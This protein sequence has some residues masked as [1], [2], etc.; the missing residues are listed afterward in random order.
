MKRHRITSLR[1]LLPFDIPLRRAFTKV[2][3]PAVI[4]FLPHVCLSA[5]T[6]QS[7]DPW[8]QWRGP[9]G[10]GISD[11]PN[12]PVHWSQDS[13]NIKWKA[14]IPGEGVSSPIVSNGRV[15]LTTA[16]ES[17]GAAVL[18][19]MVQ[20]AGIAL[21]IVLAAV[22][23]I[24]GIRAALK[25]SKSSKPLPRWPAIFITAVPTILFVDLALLVTVARTTAQRFFEQVGGLFA[26]V[27]TGDME[28]LWSMQEGVLAA[29]WLTSGSITLLGLAVIPA[30]LPRRSRW[31][32]AAIVTALVCILLLILLTP[33]D[34]WTEKTEWWER[35]IFTIPALALALWHFL[36]CIEI[37]PR[38]SKLASQDA[39]V[40]NRQESTDEQ[41]SAW[42]PGPLWS[43]LTAAV[44]LLLALLV[45]VPPNFIQPRLGLQRAVVSLD[46]DTGKM[47]WNKPVFSAPAE[48]IHSDNT[49]ATPTPTTDGEHIVVNFG[50]GAACLDYDGRVLWKKLDFGYIPNSRYGAASSPLLVDDKVIFVHQRELRSR[51]PTLITAC[52]KRSGEKLW[53]ISPDDI[54]GC[55]PT[56]LIYR[57]GDVVQLIIPSYQMLCSYDLSSGQSLWSVGLTT[58]QLVASPARSGSLLCVAGSTWGENA[59][60]VLRLSS[61]DPAAPP[62]VMWRSNLPVGNC[63]P[64]IYNGMLFTLTDNARVTCY[65]VLTGDVYWEKRLKGSRYLSSL[66]AGA[67]RIYASNIKGLTTVLAAD[68]QL[69]IVSENQLPG[70]LY[71]SPAVA[72]GCIL[73]RVGEYLY[74]IAPSRD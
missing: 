56:P 57:T 54:H 28:H 21:L 17:P 19:Q 18:Q 22:A 1:R 26:R 15:V 40:V 50:V 13:P 32:L 73:L 63:S 45:F 14:K 33:L 38:R 64:V 39:G 44:L 74:C 41:R 71:A 60:I 12:L 52:D 66:L 72:D 10:L 48:R 70:R 51:R 36:G 67:G 43:V 35:L 9:E 69:K 20:Y 5:A 59:T 53:R 24:G 31:R 47:L 37:R 34:Q 25:Q 42:H 68:A 30:W 2:F 4:L 23:G 62:E 6:G 8:P 58:E 3:V 27:G 61:S 55:Y 46:L 29:V 49:Y 65:D 16:Y 7:A 11:E